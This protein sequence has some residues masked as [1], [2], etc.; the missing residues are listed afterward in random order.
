MVLTATVALARGEAA[1][2]EADA[3]VGGSV[4]S[5]AGDPA[6]DDAGTAGHPV[7]A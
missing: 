3:E 1:T 6:S 7:V 2:M 4:D 5:P